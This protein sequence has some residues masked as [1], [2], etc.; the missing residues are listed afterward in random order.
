M[1]KWV[2]AFCVIQRLAEI[3][4]SKANQ[5]KLIESGFD[6]RE[7]TGQLGVMVLV[8]V[9]WFVSMLVEA[10]YFS[11][12]MSDLI[13]TV[14]LSLFIAAQLLR[15][16]T[17]KTL[18]QHWNI[19][20]LAPKEGSAEAGRGAFVESGPY[21]YIRHPNYL[22][23]IFE[24]FSLPLLGGAIWTAIIF[25]I[26]NGVVLKRRIL[27]EETFLVTRLGYLEKMG[28]KARLIPGVL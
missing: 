5:R 18:G 15:I 24:F 25:S 14:A 1:F 16:W 27:I 11:V 21:R 17:I 28:K 19:S 4:L 26:L 3:Y 23:V 22:A 7:P 6:F 12:S 10:T 13:L 2:F 9:G 20:V 8:H